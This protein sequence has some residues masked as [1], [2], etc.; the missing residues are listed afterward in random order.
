MTIRV[1][2]NEAIEPSKNNAG[3][4]RIPLSQAY[5]PPF[6]PFQVKH[7]ILNYASV[8]VDA[9]TALD[10]RG[11]MVFSWKLHHPRE[12]ILLT[13]NTHS[14]KMV[15]II[16]DDQGHWTIQFSHV[17]EEKAEV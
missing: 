8:S 14:F 4:Q 1:S 13:N 16:Y 17:S 2:V 7:M 12:G 11:M 10:F 9:D 6:S 5:L 3:K 15:A